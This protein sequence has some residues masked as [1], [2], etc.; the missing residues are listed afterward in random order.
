MATVWNVT[1]GGATIAAAVAWFLVVGRRWHGPVA[2]YVWPVL[3]CLFGARINGW[4][5]PLG[6]LGMA[7]AVAA[8]RRRVRREPA[9]TAQAASTAL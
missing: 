6:G 1:C 3:G 8:E 4:G 9:S 7:A 5:V 2:R